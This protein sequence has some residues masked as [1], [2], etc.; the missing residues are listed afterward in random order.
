MPPFPKTNLSK[1]FP[2]CSFYFQARKKA[3][4]HLIGG[5]LSAHTFNIIATDYQ[6]ITSVQHL[7]LKLVG[8]KIK[9]LGS[10][11]AAAIATALLA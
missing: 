5:L 3:E 1:Q 9:I 8:T 10:N 7:L 2:A 4:N 11:L 6:R